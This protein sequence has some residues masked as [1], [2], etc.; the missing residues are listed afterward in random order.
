MEIYMTTKTTMKM[1]T[2]TS[3]TI[4]EASDGTI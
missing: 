3:L 2:T 4:T 1:T